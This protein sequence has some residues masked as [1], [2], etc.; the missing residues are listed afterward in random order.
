MN[1][2]KVKYVKLLM[3]AVNFLIILF[4]SILIYT[5]TGK[6]CREFRAQ[7][8]IAGVEYIPLKREVVVLFSIGV[9]ALWGLTIIF[10]ERLVDNDNVRLALAFLWD[11]MCSV[12]I[13]FVIGMSFHCLVLLAIA[14]SIEYLREKKGMF[15]ALIISL[16]I[17][18]AGDYELLSNIIKVCS[19]DNYIDYYDAS[20]KLYLLGIKNG[21]ISLS[22]IIFVVFAILLMLEQLNE[23]NKVMELYEELYKT[24]TELEQANIQLQDYAVQKEKLGQTRERNRL[25]REIHDTLGHALTGIS[26]GVD[27]CITTIETSPE[28]TKKQ[29]EVIG[30]VA[31]Q[32]IKD[33]RR[34]VNELRPDAL[35]RFDLEK[36]ILKLKED[37]EEISN[38]KITIYN[39]IETLVFNQD[40]EELIYRIIQECITNSI[41]HGDAKH[42]DIYIQKVY[43]QLILTVKDDGRGCREMRSGFGT[44]HMKE[45]VEMLHGSIYY[46]GSD[47]FIVTA[48]I[49]IRWGSGEGERTGR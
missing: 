38:V 6:V 40:E 39:D 3:L 4:F 17:F 11:I 42:I 26:A 43:E 30:N 12:S 14:N 22:I 48:H 10:R 33:I 37:T 23:K 35:E 13:M 49:P 8:F 46:D 34:S 44:V 36:A 9:Y 2:K 27:A 25:A 7:E 21:L 31:R 45:R 28:L 41:R 24:N 1:S 29:L 5:T 18:I 20:A 32:G 15:L 47:G 19:I 16:L